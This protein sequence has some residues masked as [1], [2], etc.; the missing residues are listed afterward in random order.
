[1]KKRKKTYNSWQ[2]IFFIICFLYSVGVGIGFLLSNKFNLLFLAEFTIMK[3]NPFYSDFFYF[4]KLLIPVWISGL[5]SFGIFFI[6]PWIV[7]CGCFY[8]VSAN[9]IIFSG[10]ISAFIYNII[11][12]FLFTS[13]VFVLS[14]YAI[15]LSLNKYKS[16]KNIKASLPR[17]KRRIIA[18]YII[19]LAAG[20]VFTSLAAMIKL[21]LS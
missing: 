5:F 3:N 11:Q 4:A 6:L 8:G 1:M 10:N 17:E 21:S 16:I 20:I 12:F 15:N 19:I 7:V 14:S 2:I 13:A 18:E 9:I